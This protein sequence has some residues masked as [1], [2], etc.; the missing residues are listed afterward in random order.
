MRLRPD[1]NVTPEDLA[2]GR[3]ALVRDA[4]WATT[5]GSL[6]GGV[7]LVGFA[8]EL[9]ASPFIIGLLAAIPF[10]AQLSQA[11][12]IALVER[13]RERRK[14]TLAAVTIAR[15]LI[16]AL[17][18]IPFI[19]GQPLQ[20][21][22]LVAAQAAISLAGSV[23]GCAFNAWVHQVVPREELGR[24]FSRRLF[25]STV[26]STAGA[27]S[28]GF[29]VQAWPPDAKLQAYAIA[30]VAAG[31]AGFMSS[32][33]LLQ[34]PEPPMP[35][36]GAPMPLADMLRAPFFDANF[37][38]VIAFMASWNLASNIAA[39]FITV[40]LLRQIGLELGTLTLTWAAGQTATALTMAQWGRLSDRL[41]NKAILSV[42]LPLYFASLIALPFAAL[43]DA[44]ALTL[45][46]VFLIQI[47]MGAATGGIGLATGNL[48]LKLAPQGQGTGYLAVVSLAGSTAAGLAALAGGA[49]A[50]WF[51]A[52]ELSLAL[53]W[54][55]PGA[56]AQ[57]TVLHFR[58]WEFLF[59]IS[60]ALGFYVLHRLSRIREGEEHSERTVIQQFVIEAFRSIDQLSPIEGL[61][62]V[63]LLPFPRL[64]ERRLKPRSGP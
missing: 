10:L 61:R 59:A 8:L 6:Y 25:W 27:L 9:G 4:A 21:A 29:L 3:R 31:F 36:S 15:T 26:L 57:V 33:Y 22:L 14:I 28:A 11:A 35:R 43:P 60:F 49:L 39:P 54:T 23:G 34:V 45:A 12:T 62:T 48:G 51:A 19:E 7:I 64:R 30:F 20:L 18:F 40:Y 63:I 17:A 5:A 55:S 46:L 47:V 1:E 13:V 52:R 44:Y 58:H 24:L 16:L 53:Q 41:S 2:R 50:D 38:N 37:R 42:A 32:H 56:K